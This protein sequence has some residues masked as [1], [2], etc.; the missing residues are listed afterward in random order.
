MQRLAVNELV[1]QIANNYIHKFSSIVWTIMSD[2]TT[3]YSDTPIAVEPASFPNDCLPPEADY[4]SRDALV[5]AINTWAATRGYAFIT[6]KSTTKSSGKRVV[7]YA[8]DRSWKPP[9]S[10]D[11]ERK[12]KTTTR[13]TSCP[14]SC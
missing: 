14:F 12:R 9:T 11:I 7:T 1:I 5:T 6:R 4:A 2:F 3:G 8:C 10:T 13:G